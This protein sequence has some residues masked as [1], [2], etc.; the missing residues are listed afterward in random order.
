MALAKHITIS[1]QTDTACLITL[2]KLFVTDGKLADRHI[3]SHPA[4]HV[5]EE[6]E[7]KRGGEG[8][9]LAVRFKHTRD[10]FFKLGFPSKCP[11][12][13]N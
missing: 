8:R 2:C 6:E 9:Q 12:V 11:L 5:R 3:D 7:E 10:V 13:Y 4:T 1:L